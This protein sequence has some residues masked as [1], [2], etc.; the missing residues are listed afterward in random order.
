[1]HSFETTSGN[2]Q[3]RL[4]QA[5]PKSL[6]IFQLRYMGVNYQ[7]CHSLGLVTCRGVNGCVVG[8]VMQLNHLSC[9]CCKIV[10]ANVVTLSVAHIISDWLGQKYNAVSMAMLACRCI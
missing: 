2:R 8:S 3:F 5:A 4:P 6:V 1:E 10:S 9:L 7:R